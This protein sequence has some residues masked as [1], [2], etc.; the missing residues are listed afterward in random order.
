MDGRLDG[1]VEGQIKLYFLL[2]HSF[3]FYYTQVL[4]LKK[5]H[6]Q[7]PEHIVKVVR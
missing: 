5:I 7:E 4:I 1:P 6:W 2:F 3:I